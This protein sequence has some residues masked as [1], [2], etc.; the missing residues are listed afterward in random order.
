MSYVRRCT[1]VA[2][3]SYRINNTCFTELVLYLI[4]AFDYVYFRLYRIVCVKKIWVRLHSV[5]QHYWGQKLELKN[6]MILFLIWI[7]PFFL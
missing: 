4:L 6:Q 1:K 5:L 3:Q 7:N 2:V